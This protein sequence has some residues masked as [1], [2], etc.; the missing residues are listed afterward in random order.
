LDAL[1]IDRAFVRD[2]TSDPDDAAIALA[3][4]RLAQS[5][6]LEVVAEGVETNSQYHFLGQHGCDSMQGYFF[7]KAITRDDYGWMLAKD[8]KLSPFEVSLPSRCI[9]LVDSDEVALARLEKALSGQGYRIL[10]SMSV[11]H[12]FE[13]LAAQQVNM[14]IVEQ[15]LRPMNGV[16]FL[17]RV[18]RLYPNLIRVAQMQLHDAEMLI[19]A[20]NDASI[21]KIISAAA[22]ADLVRRTVKDAFHFVTASSSARG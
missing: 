11:E 9:L 5:L 3:V 10:K 15:A 17:S 12:A 4:I 2:I 19:E 1:K 6:R 13:Q 14:V 20:V 8:V 18:K 21:H 7:S 22:D 16:E